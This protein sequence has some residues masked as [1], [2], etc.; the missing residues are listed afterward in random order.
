MRIGYLLHSPVPGP[1]T[2]AEQA[3]NAL[4]ALQAQPDTA[5]DLWVT[6]ERTKAVGRPQ[7]EA[8]IERYYGLAP[9]TFGDRL[10]LRDVA[11]PQWVRGAAAGLAFDL[12]VP[13]WIRGERYDGLHVR[14]PLTLL[15]ALA[16]GLPVVFET[17]RTDLNHAPWWAAFRRAAWSRPN[18]AGVIAHSRVAL[19]GFRARGFA[20]ERL[21]LAYNGFTP[22]PAPAREAAR[23]TLG[24]GERPTVCYT[25]GVGRHKG[26]EALAVLAAEVP[27][28]DFLVVGATHERDVE[29]A[30]RAVGNLRIVPRVPP[31][32]VATYLA[33]ADVLVIPPTAGPLRRSG[34][35]VLPIKTFSYLAA[36]RPILAPS[37]PDITEVL[38]PD[39]ALLVAPDDLPAA[40]AALRRLFGDAALRQRLAVAAGAAAG[41]YTWSARA[42]RVAA[43]LRLCLTRGRAHP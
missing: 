14:D 30:W 9:G 40:A 16:T 29:P 10:R 22:S 37:L 11:L 17:Y 12:G 8:D 41:Q 38:S 13:R 7:R 18:L 31:A 39:I 43:F 21:L 3:V 19:D 34:R 6:G 26:I 42:A 33:A 5:V 24:L 25:G 23:Q 1:T 27:E 28:A 15:R 35:T 32:S 4:A 2:N 20:D 36:A